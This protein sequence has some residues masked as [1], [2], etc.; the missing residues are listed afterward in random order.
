MGVLKHMQED[1]K[2]GGCNPLNPLL[3]LPLYIEQL[4]ERMKI[5]NC[6]LYVCYWLHVTTDFHEGSSYYF[7]LYFYENGK[8][9]ILG[10]YCSSH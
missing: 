7:E 3:D 4:H 6:M 9:T 1:S 2:T 10:F 5:M 8:R